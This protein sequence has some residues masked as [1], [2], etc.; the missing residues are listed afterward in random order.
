VNGN[1]LVGL[2][3]GDD[4][5]VY[6]I[7]AERALIQTVDFITPVV[8]DPHLFG[9]IAA[10]NSLSDV[11][12][13]GGRPLTAL[14]VLCYPACD[15]TPETLAEILAGG[16][17]K[18][19]EAGASLLGGHTVDNPELVYGLAVTGLVAPDA[20]LA[21]AGARP[22]DL[23]VLTK[24]LGLGL[25]ATAFKAGLA[26]PEHGQAMGVVM[27]A[28]NRVAAAHLGEFGA[29]AVTDVTG[30]G[31]AGHAWAVARE[32]GVV[33]ALRWADV[34]VLPGARDALRLGLVPAGAY[35]NQ[36]AYADRLQ[37]TNP[38]AEDVSLLLCDPQTSGGLLVALPAER[39]GPYVA[40]L[41]GEGI[42]WAAIIG[43]VREGPP[44]LVIA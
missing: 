12:A 43:E 38:D 7:D 8:D 40:R 10:A 20:V 36:E 19:R 16:A 35:R 18:V 6:R 27:A 15:L 32:S 41:R 9:Q 4:A 23:L 25:L 34:P 3:T 28:L 5:G 24:P 2:H 42:G 1:V 26:A 30:F 13:M 21:N 31:L 39:A 17:A 22:G 44:R 29:R 14:N 33:L 11:Y 37:V